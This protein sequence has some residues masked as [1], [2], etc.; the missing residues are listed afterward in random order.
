L[1]GSEPEWAA[2]L[3][4]KENWNDYDPY[5]G[6]SV[7]QVLQERWLATPERPVL[8]IEPK[9]W[10]TRGELDELVSRSARGLLGLG[11]SKGDRVV[12][13]AVASPE[14]IA[15]VLATMTIG[16]I[17]VPTNPSYQRG[18]LK[19]VVRLVEPAAVYSAESEV[20]GWAKEAAPST[21]V[22]GS[23]ADL[24]QA[25]TAERVAEI[26]RSDPAM[27]FMTSGTTGESKGV[28]LSHGNLLAGA[29]AVIVAWRWS[30]DDRLILQLPLFHVHGLAIGLLGTLL[31]GG[32]AVVLSKFDIDRVLESVVEHKAT[33]LFGVP[34]TYARLVSADDVGKLRALRLCVSGSA[35]LPTTL[36]ERFRQST[37]HRLLERYG[38]TESLLTLS[39]L[40]DGPRKQGTVGLPLPG[41]EARVEN[42]ER[43]DDAGELLVRGPSVFS[44][45]WQRSDLTQ[46]V[47]TDDGW[48]R[49]GDLASRDEDGY[50]RIVGRLKELIIT[51]G[52]NVY[53][54]EV[55]AALRQ[56]KGVKDVAVIGV[57]SE[58]W[59][60]E[61]VAFVVAD[62]EILE[63]E[64]VGI[65][66]AELAPFKR[67]KRYVF[68]KTIPVNAMGK[69]DRNVLKE[70]FGGRL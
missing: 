15:M 42:L 14:Y 68:L 29:R 37:G 55:E 4:A 30:A 48:L 67:P 11:V 39:N 41:V 64:L 21:T 35:P 63:E 22:V 34:T 52:E 17:A 18:E 36:F 19:R 40:H 23:P 49:T 47:F 24:V 5:E 45:Y 3:P 10:I 57:P 1:R 31:V 38:M 70:H 65:S 56:H 54:G 20:L 60:E 51:G 16:A 66:V 28:V 25:H 9:W 2:H 61:V 32:S 46:R 69:V 13:S 7:P 27:I 50:F 26:D 33:M 59:G 8:N 6:Q 43:V 53:P 44:G 62:G 12:L 58:A